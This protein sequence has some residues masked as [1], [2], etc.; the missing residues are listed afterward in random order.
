MSFIEIPFFCEKYFGLINF[1]KE[2]GLSRFDLYS[3]KENN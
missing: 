3:L 1:N 2:T